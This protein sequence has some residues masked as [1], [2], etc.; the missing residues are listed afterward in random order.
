MITRLIAAKKN[1]ISAFGPSG[2]ERH[3]LIKKSIQELT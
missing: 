3:L 1:A 2:H